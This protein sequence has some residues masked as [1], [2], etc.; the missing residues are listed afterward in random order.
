MRINPSRWLIIL[1]LMASHPAALNAQP[2]NGSIDD[3]ANAF[4]GGTTPGL[5][6]LV[7]NGGD[8]LHIAGYGM[9]DI[10]DETPITAQSIFDLA[11]VS[12]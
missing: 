8:V 5:G 2:H 1:G 4:V 7:T 6:V 3:L 9:A 11:A 10:A 12:K